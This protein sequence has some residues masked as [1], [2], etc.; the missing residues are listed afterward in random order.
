MTAGW[1]HL[2]L[3]LGIRELR[4]ATYLPVS[5]TWGQAIETD[6]QEA[7]EVSVK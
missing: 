5:C 4:A 2:Q 7:G 1:D 3:V 6:G